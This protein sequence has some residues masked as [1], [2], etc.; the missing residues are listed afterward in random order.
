[1]YLKIFKNLL[2]VTLCLLSAIHVL[3]LLFLKAGVLVTP[4]Y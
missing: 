3:A 1:M 4:I 2:H